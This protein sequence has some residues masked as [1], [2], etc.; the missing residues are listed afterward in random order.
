MI[1]K[2]G[3]VITMLLLFIELQYFGTSL[4]EIRGYKKQN[5]CIYTTSLKN[6]VYYKLL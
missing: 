3:H 1:A 4:N 2:F 6:I 5:L